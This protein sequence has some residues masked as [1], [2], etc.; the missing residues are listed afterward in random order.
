MSTTSASSDQT[1]KNDTEQAPLASPSYARKPLSERLE[2]QIQTLK[3]LATN[4]NDWQ[5]MMFQSVNEKVAS[6]VQ[7]LKVLQ[8]M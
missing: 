6:M 3:T 2:I 4:I 8:K 5:I 7:K 1:V